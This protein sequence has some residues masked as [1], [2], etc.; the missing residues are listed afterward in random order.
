[1][2]DTPETLADFLSSFSYGSRSD[3]SFKFLARLSEAEAAEFLRR[4]L[5]EVGESFDSGSAVAI[6]DLVYEWQVE[7]YDGSRSRNPVAALEGRP[8]AA[9][10]APLSDATVGL[11]SSGG[12]YVAGRDPTPLGVADMTQAEAVQ[13]IDDFLAGAPDLVEIP[14]HTEPAELRVRHPGYDVRSARRDA[15]VVLPYA[16]LGRLAAEGRIGAVAPAVHSFIGAT[17]QG[18][19]RRAL[20]GWIETLR[21]HGVDVLLLVPV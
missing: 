5:E 8:F 7:A 18:H 17:A 15:D 16:V 21:G 3:L 1:M 11:I 4:L 13:R 14:S 19:L 10:G 9:L 12:H 6:H 20:P 2:S